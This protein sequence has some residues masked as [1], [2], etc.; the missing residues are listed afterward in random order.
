M[1]FL[2]ELADDPLARAGGLATTLA[3]LPTRAFAT[4][5]RRV[6]RGLQQELAALEHQP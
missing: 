4:T 2:D 6:W 5:K 1:G 3:A